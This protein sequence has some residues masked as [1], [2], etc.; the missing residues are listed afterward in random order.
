MS[1]PLTHESPLGAR[2]LAWAAER[3]PAPNGVFCLVLYGAALI[4]GRTS[5]GQG[6][7][8]I[9]AADGAGFLAA[10]AFLLMLRVF[11]E[12]KDFESDGRN[13]PQRV[14]QRGQIG[15]AHV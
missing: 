13:F 11:D 8:A 9:S 7:I 14:L 2:L 1:S 5:S 15:R 6:P 3:F 10:Y 12:H 4:C